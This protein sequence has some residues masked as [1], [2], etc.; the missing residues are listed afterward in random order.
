MAKVDRCQ[1][2]SLFCLVFEATSF[3]V[4]CTHEA[5]SLEPP[6]LKNDPSFL[7][8]FAAKIHHHGFS[9]SLQEYTDGHAEGCTK[10]RTSKGLADPHRFWRLFSG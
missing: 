2:D 1:P 5:E 3:Y 6:K 8:V 10:V 9:G 4:D 7:L